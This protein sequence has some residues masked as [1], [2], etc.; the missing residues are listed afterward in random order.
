MKEKELILLIGPA[1]SGK[2]T[3]AEKLEKEGY[4]KMTMSNILRKYNVPIPKTG[5]VDDDTVINALEKALKDS[6]DKV[7]L[8]GFPRTPN[9][10]LKLVSSDIRINRALVLNVNL[11]TLI[12]RANDRIVCSKCGQS[13][14]EIGDY[15][16]PKM[17][18]ICDDCKAPLYKRAEDNPEDVTTR[19]EEYK[20][21]ENSILNILTTNNVK[22]VEVDSSKGYL[23]KDILD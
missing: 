13:Y 20:E 4:E 19:Y 5:L 22:I 7:V 12:D 3:L 11:Q 2:G 16:K 15:K 9:Q 17:V 10:A 18:G 21:N 8:D 6:S 1:A 23:V 14:T